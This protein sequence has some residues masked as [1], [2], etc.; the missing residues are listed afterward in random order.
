MKM[1][2]VLQKG[3]DLKMQEKRFATIRLLVSHVVRICGGVELGS[4]TLAVS[5]IGKHE[6]VIDW[7]CCCT[8]D[9]IITRER[10]TIN[11]LR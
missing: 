6:S 2:S 9:V 7:T 4:P 1:G 5:L 10:K 8:G 11:Q 3:L